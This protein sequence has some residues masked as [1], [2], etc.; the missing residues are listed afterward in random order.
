MAAVV[1]THNE[2]IEGH[3]PTI[4][5]TLLADRDRLVPKDH[6]YLNDIGHLPEDSC[7]CYV[8]DILEVAI[9]VMNRPFDRNTHGSIPQVRPCD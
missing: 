7:E 3:R 5:D 8:A 9:E 6:D 2:V 4:H 1:Q